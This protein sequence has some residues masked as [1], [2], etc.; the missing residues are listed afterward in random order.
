MSPKTLDYFLELNPIE[1]AQKNSKHFENDIPMSA[2]N[3]QLSFKAEVPVLNNYYFKNKDVFIRKHNRFAPYP[4]H[5][6]TFLE[7]NYMLQG[8]CVEIVDGETLQLKTGDLLLLDVGCKHS[9]GQLSENDIL[10]NIMFRD[11]DISINMLNDLRRNQSV[12]YEFLLNRTIKKENQRKFMIFQNRN[13]NEVQDTLNHLIDEYIQSK[14]FANT[15]IKSYL[16]ILLT[17]LIRNYNVK[18]KDTSQSQRLIL[19]ILKDITKNYQHISLEALAVK[20]NY[21]KNYLSNLFK[22]EV[23]KTFSETLTQERLIHARTMV[24]STMIPI[25]DIIEEIGIT[26]KNFFYKKYKEIYHT[27]PGEDR[28]QADKD[29]ISANL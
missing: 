9:L 3:N 11:Q 14:E 23:G 29:S 4:T 8:E 25:S 7:M 15:I 6:H 28:T 19:K 5:T 22:K 27:T 24:T 13:G 10:V 16:S 21:N 18:T 1:K 2:I 17:Q 20:Y 12:F 26:N